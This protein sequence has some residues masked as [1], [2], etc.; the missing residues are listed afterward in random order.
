MLYD[1]KWDDK[2]A[3]LQAQR[4]ALHQAADLI[5]KHGHAKYALRNSE[6]RL[7]LLGAIN[8]AVTGDPLHEL[9]ASCKLYCKVDEV[10][11]KNRPDFPFHRFNHAVDWNNAPE[12]KPEEVIALLR[13][14]ADAV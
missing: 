1:K 13:E 10:V 11:K 14:A 7:C 4:A 6:G 5:E 9:P 3:E 12:R 8:M 2:F